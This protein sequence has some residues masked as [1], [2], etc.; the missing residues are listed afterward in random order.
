[1]EQLMLWLHFQCFPITLGSMQS[2]TLIYLALQ[3]SPT[4]TPP[5][6]PGP[7]ASAPPSF[8]FSNSP[9]FYLR[10]GICPSFWRK[11]LPP[12]GMA[13]PLIQVSPHMSSPHRAL[14]CPSIRLV[15]RLQTQ[16]YHPILFCILP[17]TYCLTSACL[18]IY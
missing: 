6:A 18:F 9:T 16:V 7:A 5:H 17:S 14:P 12:C 3:P 4:S 10:L 8:C 15:C 2:P 13:A 11:T 1:M